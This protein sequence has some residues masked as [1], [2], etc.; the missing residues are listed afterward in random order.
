MSV[1][2]L[3]VLVVSLTALSF[4]GGSTLQGFLEREL[5]GS[6]MVTSEE[7]LNAIALGQSTPGPLAAFTTAAGKAALGVPGAIAATLGL[8]TVSLMAVQIISRMP[9]GWFKQPAVRNGLGGVAP[10]IAAL[11]FVLAWRNLPTVTPDGWIL[12]AV[13]V[14]GVVAG[15]MA[16]LSTPL[17]M[18]GAVAAGMLLQGT[19]LAS[20]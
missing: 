2:E 19:S 14:A 17:L 15:R 5:V 8:M 18:L 13:I 11:V 7:Y 20:W 6:G 3:Y 16:K 12:P 4:G 10:F 1:L 9:A